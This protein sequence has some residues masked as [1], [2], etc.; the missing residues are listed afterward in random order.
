[1]QQKQ[2]DVHIR[3]RSCPE[4]HTRYF[5]SIF[6]GH[7]TASDLK[8]K[9]DECLTKLRKGNVVQLGMDGLS[10]NWKL[11]RDIQADVQHETGKKMV[12]VGSC[13]LH[14]VHG[15]FRDG[16]CAVS[17]DIESFLRAALTSSKIGELEGKIMQLLPHRPFFPS[18]S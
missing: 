1:M 14:T 6:M 15:A 18:S 4:V 3:F 11:F 2:L 16:I 9:I 7:A 10:V 13:E 8:G 5:T 17:W 12:N